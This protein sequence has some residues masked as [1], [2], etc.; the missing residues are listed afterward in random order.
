MLPFLL[1]SRQP[2]VRLFELDDGRFQLLE[3]GPIGP[4]LPGHGYLL[5]ERALAEFL[6]EHHVERIGFQD[7]ILFD[8][9]S[10]QEFRTHVRVQVRQY[11]T[12]EQLNDLDLNG[13]RLLTMNDEY[14]FASPE[15]KEL[16]ERSSFGYLCF[17]E[18]LA[19]F[20]GA[21]S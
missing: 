1:E 6:S 18:G 3:P 21:S 10:G 13:L 16:L 15:L 20:A 4:F 2:V 19:G 8:R 7:A 5:V 12:S 9:R 11:F 14:C 17:S